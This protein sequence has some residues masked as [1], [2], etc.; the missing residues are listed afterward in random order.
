MN[1]ERG[2]ATVSSRLGE[3]PDHPERWEVDPAASSLT[4]RLRHVVISEI[5]GRFARWG[6]SLFLDRRHPELSWLE[7]WLDLTSI[8]TGDPERDQHMRS[9]E[10]LDIERHP[11]AT[12]RSTSVELTPSGDVFVRGV[13][14]L[15]AHDRDVDLTVTPGATTIEA[16]GVPRGRYAARATINRQDFGLRWNQDLDIGGVVVGDHVEVEAHVELLRAP[17]NAGAPRA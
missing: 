1:T 4:F 2:N 3:A 9:A 16:S 7:V 12:F 10:F 14:H 5:R 11:Q 8:D 17:D 13:L 15:H 6:G